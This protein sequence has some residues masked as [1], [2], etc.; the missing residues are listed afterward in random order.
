VP[1]QSLYAKIDLSRAISV[2]ADAINCISH[3]EAPDFV[4]DDQALQKKPERKGRGG[5]NEGEYI[6]RF[7]MPGLDPESAFREMAKIDFDTSLSQSSA[8]TDK[9]QRAM[10]T[11]GLA[12]VCLQQ[13]QQKPKPKPKRSAGS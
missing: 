10:S 11:L 2:L 13:A 5:R 12:D 6:F 3:I 9:F 7:Y 4:G 1:N 8:L